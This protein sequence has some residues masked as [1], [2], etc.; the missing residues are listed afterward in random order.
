MG[1][2]RS[3]RGVVR[4]L[5]TVMGTVFLL[6][7]GSL[8]LQSAPQIKSDQK[9]KIK[10]TIVSRSGDLVKVTDKKAGT[11]V[12]VVVND[13]TKVERNNF[14]YQFFVHKDMDMTALVPGLTIEAEGVGN[15]KGQLIAKTISFVPDAFA[16]EVAE[17][18]QIMANQK[19]AAAAQ[20]TANQGVQQA[21]GAQ[22]SANQ[23]QVS[24]DVAQAS[25]NKAGKEAKEA[26]VV[27]V[28]DAADIALVNKRVSDLDE[29]KVVGEAGIYF[30]NNQADLDAA[31]QADLDVL[32]GYTKGLDNYMIEI[33]GYA[34]STGTKQENQKLSADRA[35]AVAHYLMEKKN[36]P[37]RR[38]LAPAGY[39][40]SHPAASNTD[41]QGR[42][43][44]RR[45]DVKVLMNKG[46]SEG[47]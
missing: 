32:A 2:I 44:N 42:A 10:G 13:S 27:A 20:S 35:A 16:I 45:V 46:L 28:Y 14:K 41:A 24:A 33:T 7:L 22:A 26:G 5:C 19:A 21:Q 17:E 37:M 11:T 47:S 9:A 38:I 36:I 8:V 40:A 4:A 18:K 1:S 6:T 43:L 30:A 31:A 23:A 12:I 15:A 39:G 29:Y 34:S 25:A 3:A